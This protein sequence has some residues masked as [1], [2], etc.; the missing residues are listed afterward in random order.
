ME[1]LYPQKFMVTPLKQLSISLRATSLLTKRLQDKHM[2]YL[3]SHR[4]SVCSSLMLS[5]RDES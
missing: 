5:A 4:P 2:V 1:P 3:K